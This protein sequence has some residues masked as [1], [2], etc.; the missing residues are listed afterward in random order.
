MLFDLTFP[1]Y[2][3]TFSGKTCLSG[4]VICAFF[5]PAYRSSSVSHDSARLSQRTCN[6]TEGIG[7]SY[8]EADGVAGH[9]LPRQQQ[10]HQASSPQDLRRLSN[11]SLLGSEEEERFTGELR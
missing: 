8:A 4:K 2:L 11:L 1:C 9:Q 7:G 6:E 10:Q 5:C 3:T